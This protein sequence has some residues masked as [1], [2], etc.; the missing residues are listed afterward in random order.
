MDSTNNPIKNFFTAQNT[1]ML[2]Q[3]I[4][5]GLR[6]RYKTNLDDRYMEQL[7]ELMKMVVEP[8]PKRMPANI[9]QKKLIDTLN[10]QVLKE[11]VP[12][13][14]SIALNK[15]SDRS[16][17][18][19]AIA[20]RLVP[21]SSDNARMT[22][23]GARPQQSTPIRSVQTDDEVLNQL[24]SDR[25]PHVPSISRPKFEEDEVEHTD[26][27]NDL[28]E[29]AE[30]F[31]QHQDVLPPPPVDVPFETRDIRRTPS[32][33]DPAPKQTGELPPR[34]SERFGEEQIRPL[35]H[36]A[37]FSKL[38]GETMTFAEVAPQPSEMR[39]LIPRDSRNQVSNSRLIPHIFVLSSSERY[40]TAYPSA[41]QF[42][43]RLRSPYT[44]VVSVELTSAILPLSG[45]N[46]NASNNVIF[47]EESAGT[48]LA[49]TLPVGNYPDANTV[50]FAAAASLTAAT[51][52]GV[53]YSGTADPL[54]NKITITSDGASGAIFSLLFI[55]VPIVIEEGIEKP[56]FPP[57]SIGEVLGFNPTNYIG[58]LN[59][60]APNVP[61]LDD[62][63]A[64]YLHIDELEHLESNNSA[65]HNA[66]AVIPMVTE[67][68][69][70][71]RGYILFA[72]KDHPPIKNFSP[73]AGKISYLT[74]SIRTA[75][76]NLYDFNGRDYVL[77]LKFTSQDPAIGPYD[78]TK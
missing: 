44:D 11:A 68:T 16:A 47:F 78:E 31:R 63:P 36:D 37:D 40:P 59:Y 32:V 45:Y 24:I 73:P 61:N 1:K 55:G 30:H 76:G 69:F 14:A 12:I 51:S 18:N 53:T 9:D 62:E 33:Y 39:V 46:I 20:S 56:Q 43:I 28:Y 19:N 3:I 74:I 27:I 21:P 75:A 23:G 57:N 70:P 4:Q 2:Y 29:R 25:N 58:A 15:E 77:T 72:D 7:I 34:G 50:A 64:V 6:E 67:K 13:F 35:I 10:K 49:A 8:L 22:L 48:T 60:T 71:D 66:F 26:D 17:V 42:R 41:S 5:Q 38:A 52:L 65:I 54:S